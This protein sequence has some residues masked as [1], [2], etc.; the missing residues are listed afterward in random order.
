LG[1]T[2]QI[3]STDK[4]LTYVFKTPGTYKVRLAA[5][6]G[7]CFDTTNPVT[8]VVDDP[9]A[10]GVVYVTKVECY[11]QN[12]LKI[13]LYFNNFGYKTIPKGTPTGFYN[14]GVKLGSYLL[15]YDIQ[16]KCASYL[17]TFI[18][19]ADRAGLDTV[20]AQFNDD[21]LLVES[22]YGNNFVTTKNFKFSIQLLP[23]D[24]TLTPEQQVVL[25][26]T[27]TGNMLSATWIPA[28]YVSC[29]PCMST[30]FTA[31]YRKDT[32]FLQSVKVMTDNDCYDSAF[33]TIHIPPVDDYVVNVVTTECA[34]NDS[35]YVTYNICDTYA[36][37][38]VP[39][40]FKVSFYDSKMDTLGT[41]FITGAFST[42]P[43]TPYGQ[44]IKNTDDG[45]FIVVVNTDYAW[46]ET[47]TL[48]NGGTG[49]YIFPTARVVPAD[50]TVYRGQSF[51]MGFATNAFR[52]IDTLWKTG[53]TYTLSCT[54][55]GFPI[56]KVWDSSNVHLQLTNLYGCVLEP[57]AVI[58]IVPPDLTITISDIQCYDNTHSIVSFSV[59]TA[60][61][62]DSIKAQ[63]PVGFY[64]D[65]AHLMEPVFYTPASVY[66]TCQDYT[67]IVTT[68][69]GS[70]LHAMVNDQHPFRETDYD[71]NSADATVTPFT[72]GFEPSVIELTRPGSV[73]LQPLVN[74]GSANKY[75]WTPVEG[76]SCS[77]CANPTV[78]ISSSVKYMVEVLNQ[79][80]CTDTA[81]IALHTFTNSKFAIPTA[82]TPNGDG[83]N[84]VFYII[85]T[86]DIKIIKSFMIFTRWGNK[87]FETSNV[88]A[89][90]K[91]YGWKGIGSAI[92][93]YVYFA[94]VEFMDGSTEV[95]KGSVILIK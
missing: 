95:V 74:G 22:N 54:T 76:L 26:P 93:P 70:E 31:P 50:T 43:C 8:I 75:T 4:D 16:G 12:K 56:I 84:D 91:T 63:L 57:E 42:D 80:F 20:T 49:Q 92:G 46:L 36:K 15:P 24:I 88:P 7:S 79:Y 61:G 27:S 47:D 82:F 6:N 81:A 48:N 60:N 53:S 2:E 69:F 67:H 21:S 10:D 9:T 35:I 5:D 33:V 62:Y 51:P 72:V 68:P 58:K 28:T 41:S 1:A 90:D 11:E 55:C 94:N 52:P 19:D 39:Q 18:L 34:Q 89:N 40:G 3:V 83:V 30:T 87:I 65:S 23:A 25:T 86:K 59:C 38:N 66:G 14:N 85:G 37:G 32:L 78:F 17:E 77:T 64:D 29:D 73:Q 44:K 13:S 45:S 71:N